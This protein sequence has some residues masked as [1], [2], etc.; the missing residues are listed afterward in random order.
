MAD[1]ITLWK[2]TE[3]VGGAVLGGIIGNRSDDLA[4]NNWRQF[5]EN[6]TRYRPGTNHELQRAIYQAYLQATLQICADTYDRL[7]VDASAR[8]RLELLPD[9]LAKT[10]KMFQT[11]APLGFQSQ[12]IEQ[13]LDAASSVLSDRIAN[14]RSSKL[15]LP[16]SYENP[17]FDSLLKQDELLL[18]PG[19]ALEREEQ[20]RQA[21]CTRVISG[22]GQ[23]FGQLPEI[24]A[25]RLNEKWFDYLCACFHHTIRND[26]GVANIF[27]SRLL[28]KI[29]VR[30]EKGQQQE[31]TIPEI[32]S[33]LERFSGALA[34]LI[35][36]EG[37]RVVA[38]LHQTEKRIIE[39]LSPDRIA[40]SL[41]DQSAE[42]LICHLDL[43][44]RIVDRNDECRALLEELRRPGGRR[45]IPIA[46][47]RGFGKT[48]LV[49]RLLQQVTDGERITSPDLQAIL[50][51]DGHGG[52]ITLDRIVAEAGRLSGQSLHFQQLFADQSRPLVD[53]LNRFF[54]ELS[55]AGNV[56]IVLDN[57]EDQLDGEKIKSE[58]LEAFLG[59]C[60]DQGAR[61]RVILTT[62][63]IPRLDGARHLTQLSAVEKGLSNGLPEADAINYLRSEGAGCGLGPAE[64][65]DDLLRAFA[66]RVHFNPMALASVVC[67]LSD[68][69]Y[70]GVTLSDLMKDRELFRD[71]DRHDI[72]RGLKRLLDNQLSRLKPEARMILSVLAFFGKATPQMA[73]E[74]LLP[75][76]DLAR[77]LK[78]LHKNRLVDY[79]SD[80]LG[81]TWF[82][83][84]PVIGEHQSLSIRGDSSPI[85]ESYAQ[86]CHSL[87]EKAYYKARFRLGVYLFDC[88]EAIF[89]RLVEAGR[90]ELANELAMALMNK[91]V[92]L[93]SLGQMKEAIA[94]Y[95]QAISTYQSLVEA[96][97][98]ELANDLAAALMNK[99]V[100]LGSLGQMKEAIACYDQAISTYQSLVEAGREELANEL[101]MALMNKAIALEKLE[102]RD[103]AAACYDEAIRLRVS[104]VEDRGLLHV[105]PSLL[106]TIRYRLMLLIETQRL[107]RA[108][109]DLLRALPFIESLPDIGALSESASEERGAIVEMLKGLPPESLDEIYSAMGEAAER[110]K[111]L[112]E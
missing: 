25:D 87:A 60:L 1:P 46:A 52:A 78:Y 58:E 110:L 108:G 107:D 65:P 17:E 42:P 40:Q 4:K 64:A 34:T 74:P 102:G 97:R 7:G 106:E 9:F 24:F 112:L 77:V 71:F 86:A 26:Q 79:Q 21:L 33:Q 76:A 85:N 72:E 105:L 111:R 35:K 13:W 49:I 104:C 96:G 20:I 57:F 68:E 36:S 67:Y 32:E 109:E 38:E 3:F 18:Q 91:G 94:C 92:A 88:A 10:I 66:R 27:Q 99:G 54:G 30:N 59:C 45:V 98:E 14:L 6:L 89:R 16:A 50:T 84:H 62:R 82:S 29:Y 44:A 73:L 47:P 11:S 23:E 28:A 100:A 63:T 83:P 19:D 55:R 95:D 80:R 5:R 12:A 70:P 39:S 69:V 90:E 93:R 22:L 43:R 51:L 41:R 2:V 53:R 15:D 75:R 103:E 8:L 56:W 48:S 31:I 37:D 61:V 101:A 81:A